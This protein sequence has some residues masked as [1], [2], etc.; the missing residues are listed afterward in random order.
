VYLAAKNGP[1]RA[2]FDRTIPASSLANHATDA[3]AAIG[4]FYVGRWLI[5]RS[6]AT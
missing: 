6:R 4:G 2:A 3:F 1:R 5:Q